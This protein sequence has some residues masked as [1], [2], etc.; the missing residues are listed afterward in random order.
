[1]IGDGTNRHAPALFLAFSYKEWEKPERKG[2]YGRPRRRRE[3]N[4]GTD[5]QETEWGRGLNLS[6]FG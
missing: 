5:F 4:I 3:D 1:M 6:G 2:T